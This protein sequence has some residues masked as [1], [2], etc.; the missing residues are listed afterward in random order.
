MLLVDFG[1]IARQGL[2]EALAQG[3]CDVVSAGGEVGD[4]RAHL[5]ELSPSAV[6]FDM[7]SDGSGALAAELRAG[8]HG[9][10]VIACSTERPQMRVWDR[11]GGES[12][13]ENLDP[14][15]LAAAV[16]S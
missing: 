3:G 7:D 6:V 16:R 13:V 2:R 9:A 11:D 1:A 8:F 12:H 10:R 14:G 5:R 4:L 15:R